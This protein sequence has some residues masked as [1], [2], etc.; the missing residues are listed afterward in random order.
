MY[1]KRGTESL[2][3]PRKKAL[4]KKKKKGKLISLKINKNWFQVA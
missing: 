4:K 1:K 3:K 2:A